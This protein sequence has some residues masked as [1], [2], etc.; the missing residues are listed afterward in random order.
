M[1]LDYRHNFAN[2]YHVVNKMNVNAEGW[3][4]RRVVP[5]KKPLGRG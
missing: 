3:H 4:P 2:F 5:T 1:R